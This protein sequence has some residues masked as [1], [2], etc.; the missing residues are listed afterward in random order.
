MKA[1]QC[2]HVHLKAYIFISSGFF[3]KRNNQPLAQVT[4]SEE[5]DEYEPEVESD[6]DMDTEEDYLR[7]LEAAHLERGRGAPDASGE[8]AGTWQPRPD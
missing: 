2:Q 1:S 6:V 3:S 4:D 7:K 5:E 8:R